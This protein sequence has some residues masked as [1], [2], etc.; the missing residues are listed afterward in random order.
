MHYLLTSTVVSDNL[1]S[2]VCLKHS[3]Y[4]HSINENDSLSD[5]KYQVMLCEWDCTCGNGDNCDTAVLY[6]RRVLIP[7][8]TQNIRLLSR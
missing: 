4:L 6:F 1:S 5:N 2:V 7:A 8:G 3:T